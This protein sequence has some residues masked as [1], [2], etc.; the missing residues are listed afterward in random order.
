MKY[1]AGILT[2]LVG[3]GLTVFQNCAGT[4][5]VADGAASSE[6]VSGSASGM[7]AFQSGFYAFTQTQNC[8]QCHGVSQVP[9][10]AVSNVA[11]AYSAFTS[12]V[13]PNNPTG[14]VIITYSGNG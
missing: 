7:A 13:D 10:F 5:D 9:L 4:H 1:Q 6:S 14:S 2:L 12:L 3:I 11:S 8:A